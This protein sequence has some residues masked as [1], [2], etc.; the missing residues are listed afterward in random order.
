MEEHTFEILEKG[1]SCWKPN[2]IGP[3]ALWSKK[4]AEYQHSSTSRGKEKLY[5]P[6][7][8]SWLLAKIN[9][10]NKS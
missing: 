8:I 7:M 4:R 6:H 1:Q 5:S 9:Q 3:W 2:A 10:I